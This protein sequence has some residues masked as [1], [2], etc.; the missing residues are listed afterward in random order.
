MQVRRWRELFLEPRLEAR[1]ELVRL[2]LR[3][4]EGDSSLCRQFH[5]LVR[6]RLILRDEDTRNRK[7]K[8]RRQMPMT[9]RGV[10]RAKIHDLRFAED[11][12]APCGKPL[13]VS[14]DRE[15]RTR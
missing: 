11:L 8:K 9:N 4:D 6:R 14:R 3:R 15:S 13:D 12:E 2:E 5:E 7:R 1:V 10:E